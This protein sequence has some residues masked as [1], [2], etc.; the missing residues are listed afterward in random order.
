[1][2]PD[3]MDYLE[4]HEAHRIPATDKLMAK[5]PLKVRNFYKANPDRR[6]TQAAARALLSDA[7]AIQARNPRRVVN[8]KKGPD[9]ERL[10][11]RRRKENAQ[12]RMLSRGAAAGASGA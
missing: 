3:P 9:T 4:E 6:L 8:S 1:M 2:N 11:D 7:L 12:A 10:P 5:L